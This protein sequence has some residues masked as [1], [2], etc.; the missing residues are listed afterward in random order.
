M[1]FKFAKPV[2]IFFATLIQLYLHREK[3]GKTLRESEKRWPN[4]D[5]KHNINYDKKSLQFFLRTLTPC[6][7]PSL[8]FSCLLIPPSPI[9]CFKKAGLGAIHLPIFRSIS[10]LLTRKPPPLSPLN[11][12]QRPVYKVESNRHVQIIIKFN[13]QLNNISL[14]LSLTRPP[15]PYIK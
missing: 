4:V 15:L 2:H 10:P 12:L 6:V 3:N 11:F 5:S 9:P 8:L 1:Q 7:L 14:K 13:K